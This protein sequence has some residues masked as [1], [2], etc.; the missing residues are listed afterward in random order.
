MFRLQASTEAEERR[1]KMKQAQR[2]QSLGIQKGTLEKI[3]IAFI[4]VRS[5]YLP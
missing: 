1:S 2:H 5:N 4:I 3:V